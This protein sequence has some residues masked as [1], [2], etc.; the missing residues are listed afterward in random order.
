M[1]DQDLKGMKIAILVTNGFEQV[2]MTEPRRALKEGRAKTFLI[3]P[4]TGRVQGMNHHE[5]G[6]AFPVDLT[7]EEADPEDFDGVLLPGGVRNADLLRVERKAQEFVQ[8]L[9]RQ[10]KPIAVICHG[11]WLLV[12]AELTRG[13]K[14]TSYHTLKDDILNAGGTWEDRE[15][16]RDRNWV[17]SRQPRDIPAFNREMIRLFTEYQARKGRR[18]A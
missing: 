8:A 18:A 9:D 17:S 13:R 1:A 6:D 11:P 14:L 2:E 7:L 4:Q 15:V 16:V 12:S 10:G 3:A 5:M